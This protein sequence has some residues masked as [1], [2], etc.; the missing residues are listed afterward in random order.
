MLEFP[1]I[2]VICRTEGVRSGCFRS[3]R[4]SSE[5]DLSLLEGTIQWICKSPYRP[6]HGRKNW[7]VDV[8]VCHNA[9]TEGFD[10]NSVRFETF[11]SGG[12]G[13]QHVNKVETGVRAIHVPTGIAVVCTDERSQHINKRTA[14]E[15]LR[16]AVDSLNASREASA[17][18]ENRLEH[19]RITRGNPVRVYRD[20]EFVLVRCNA[21]IKD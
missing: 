17:K 1:D 7:F 3:V 9:E 11:R 10:E 16:E 8:S 4:I 12:H 19:S 15:R 14:L 21:S 18:S 5:S 2:K 6:H 20:M 13:G